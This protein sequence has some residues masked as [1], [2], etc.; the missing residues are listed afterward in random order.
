MTE[1]VVEK[2]SSYFPCVVREIR[3]GP[4]TVKE[5]MKKCGI[6]KATAYRMIKALEEAELVDWERGEYVK[7]KSEIR[8]FTPES[9]EIALNHSK[10]LLLASEVKVSEVRLSNLEREKIYKLIK[11]EKLIENKYFIQHLETG[12]PEIYELYEEWKNSDEKEKVYSLLK[13]KM[14]FLI[15]KISHGEPLRGYCD[16]CPLVIVKEVIR[17]ETSRR[18][19]CREEESERRIRVSDNQVS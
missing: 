4:K 19:H 12:Y 15:E 13:E 1:K 2:W 7:W 14:E 5:L 10:Q 18:M 16:L 8:E 11:V 9:Y 3:K 17:N 6:P